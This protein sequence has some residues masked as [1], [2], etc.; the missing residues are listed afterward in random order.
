MSYRV[1]SL[2]TY[3]I[4]SL[5]G[6]SVNSLV[7]THSGPRYD[8]HF[9]LIDDNNTFLCQRRQ[10]DLA[11]FKTTLKNEGIRVERNGSQIDIPFN[12]PAQGEMINSKLHQE[13]IPVR[14]LHSDINTWFSEVLGQSVRVVR[15][16]KNH[17][18]HVKNHDDATVV[19][20]DSSPVLIIGQPA[21]NHLNEKINQDF[22]VLR[23]RPNIVFLNG[24]PH[25][26]DLWKS[27]EIGEGLF[28]QIKKCS[29]CKITTIDPVTGEGGVEPLKTLSSYR[30]ENNKIKFGVYFKLEN[31]GHAIVSVGDSI[32]VKS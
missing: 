32:S 18:R 30:K 6:I 21:L 7:M 19:F 22:S 3:P 11:L 16:A 1:S 24:Q 2:Y 10:P 17:M 28:N 12:A 26:E 15:Q 13:F 23:F 4:K 14:A 5:P 25:D 29:R 20:A 8:R 31:A 9:M 27:I